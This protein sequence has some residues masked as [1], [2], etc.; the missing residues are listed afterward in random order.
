MFNSYVKLRVGKTQLNWSKNGGVSIWTRQF[1]GEIH[2]EDFELGIS[3]IPEMTGAK[4]VSLFLTQ[5]RWG[6]LDINPAAGKIVPLA[7]LRAFTKNISTVLSDI[8][9]FPLSPRR[10]ASFQRSI[11]NP[12]E[13]V[14]GFADKTKPNSKTC[15][16][17]LLLYQVEYKGVFS[18]GSDYGEVS[19]EHL[20]GSAGIAPF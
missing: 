19:T 11:V 3:E 18:S 17:L 20:T 2:A 12:I 6:I 8:V 16:C 9:R 7:F 13:L 4:S 15:N 10:V 1:A 5:N 14:V